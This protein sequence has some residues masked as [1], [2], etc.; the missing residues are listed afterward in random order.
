G[1]IH[2]GEFQAAGSDRPGPKPGIAVFSLNPR[3][4]YRVRELE[5]LEWLEHGFGTRLSDVPAIFPQLTT[6][7]QVHSA[8]CVRAS[9]APGVL[10]EGDALLENSPGAVVAVKTADCVPILL[11][12]ERQRAVAAIHAGWRGV[13]AGI[14]ES[15]VRAMKEQ[16][17]TD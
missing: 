14:A 17:G 12:D 13:V 2:A 8:I 4:V 16:F 10:G 9:G 1:R 7:K 5:G 11:V 3:G 15:A 6:L